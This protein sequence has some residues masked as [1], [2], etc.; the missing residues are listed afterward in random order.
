MVA[1]QIPLSNNTGSADVYDPV[2][3]DFD[4]SVLPDIVEGRIEVGKGGVLPCEDLEC[5]EVVPETAD[6]IV[7]RIEFRIAMTEGNERIADGR[8]GYTVDTG[9]GAVAINSEKS[10]PA[11][12]RRWISSESWRSCKARFPVLNS[13]CLVSSTIEICY[14]PRWSAA[15]E[16][17]RL[18]S[19]M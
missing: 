6:R 9:P 7:A 2:V 5:F 4:P 10:A 1:N 3:P 13:R 17:K 18:P 19:R 11:R 14:S 12:T 16:R 8:P 15:F